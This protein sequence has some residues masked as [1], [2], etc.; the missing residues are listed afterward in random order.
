VPTNTPTSSPS[1]VII[2]PGAVVPTLGD[3]GMLILGLLLAGAGYLLLR[4]GSGVV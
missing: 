2:T 4:K 1:P 3:S